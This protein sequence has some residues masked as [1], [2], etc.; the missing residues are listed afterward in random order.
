MSW[1]TRV[2]IGTNWF[3]ATQQAAVLWVLTLVDPGHQ[4]IF[5]MLT[6]VQ[7]NT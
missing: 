4:Q 7:P 5:P 2:S 1:W 3:V 6:P